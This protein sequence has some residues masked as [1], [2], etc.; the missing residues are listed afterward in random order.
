[1]RFVILLVVLISAL[2]VLVECCNHQRL[3]SERVVEEEALAADVEATAALAAEVEEEAM[4]SAAVKSAIYRL[5]GG[6][7][8]CPECSEDRSIDRIA[9]EKT[10]FDGIWRAKVYVKCPEHG[11]RLSEVSEWHVSDDW[12][13][14]VK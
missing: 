13:E 6:D 5:Y 4:M 1:M 9:L 12:V 11:N 3:K 14:R 10:S 8:P 7:N 2:S